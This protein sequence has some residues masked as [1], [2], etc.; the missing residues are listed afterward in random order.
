M[1]YDFLLWYIH[2]KVIGSKTERGGKKMERKKRITNR[3]MD[4]EHMLKRRTSST[5]TEEDA[6]NFSLNSPE[7]WQ[8]LHHEIGWGP[9]FIP[10]KIKGSEKIKGSGT[11][12]LFGV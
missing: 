10:R 6:K 1:C 8:E 7:T 9:D 5:L 12:Y 3:L 4:L 11:F 2:R